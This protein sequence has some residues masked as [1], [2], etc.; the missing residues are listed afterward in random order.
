M[1]CSLTYTRV[2]CRVLSRVYT[3]TVTVLHEQLAANHVTDL[4]S[5]SHSASDF[6]SNVME[7]LHGG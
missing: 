5:A 4:C 1:A 3:H 2:R 7:Q 6:D